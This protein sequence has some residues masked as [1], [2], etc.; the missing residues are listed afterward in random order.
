MTKDQIKIQEA[1]R[2]I[3]TQEAAL[4]AM[5]LRD[6]NPGMGDSES[7]SIAVAEIETRTGIQI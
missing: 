5:D 7:L 2:N 6:A 4:R 3:L 1:A